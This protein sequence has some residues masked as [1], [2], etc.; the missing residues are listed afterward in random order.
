MTSCLNFVL[1]FHFVNYS[2]FQRVFIHCF[3]VENIGSGNLGSGK[4]GKESRSSEVSF[5][6][7]AAVISKLVYQTEDVITHTFANL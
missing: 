7:Q 4:S 6:A 5:S 3:V 2:L 1:V